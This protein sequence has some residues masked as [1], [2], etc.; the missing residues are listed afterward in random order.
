MIHDDDLPGLAGRYIYA[1]FYA[2]DLRT[3]VP[4]EDGATGDMPL[5]LNA[6]M[7]SSF[8]EGAEDGQIYVA[9]YGEPGEDGNV[10]ALEPG[11]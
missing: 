4:H 7:V 8:G 9:D 10:Y 5:G 3:L 6:G 2:G 11:T 1:D